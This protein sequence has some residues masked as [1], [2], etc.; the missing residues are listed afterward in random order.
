MALARVAASDNPELDVRS[1]ERYRRV[2]AALGSLGGEQREAIELAFYGGLSHSEIA[3]QTGEPLGTIKSRI[4]RGMSR[5]RI[6]L[7]QEEV[8]L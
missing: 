5:L 1:R 8:L 7:D 3:S 6:A 2:Q 4:K